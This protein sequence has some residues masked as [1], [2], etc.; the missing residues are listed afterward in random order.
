MQKHSP[1]N[2]SGRNIHPGYHSHCCNASQSLTTACR[3]SGVDVDYDDLAK[4]RCI[5]QGGES[6]LQT[7]LIREDLHSIS[8]VQ[9]LDFE[10]DTFL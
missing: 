2:N 8:H 10:T 7:T 6:S 5:G 4:G 3:G 9:R 1:R